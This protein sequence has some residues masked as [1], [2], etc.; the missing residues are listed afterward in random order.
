MVAYFAKVTAVALALTV[1]SSLRATPNNS[2]DQATA[3]GTQMYRY[4]RSA[5]LTS[6]DIFA[7]LP[8]ERR[9]EVVRSPILVIEPNL[10][11][12]PVERCSGVSPSHLAKNP[13]STLLENSF[14]SDGSLRSEP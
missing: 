13:L 12:P 11:L 2:L 3:R 6:D 1:G 8:Q 5:W 4:D 14:R 9:P 7:R 10:D